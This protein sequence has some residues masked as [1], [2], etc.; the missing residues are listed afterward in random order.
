MK[1]ET[2]MEKCTTY[3][4]RMMSEA[5]NETSEL[6]ALLSTAP[7]DNGIPALDELCEQYNDGEI[8][9]T[10]LVCNTWNRAY[11]AG[12]KRSEARRRKRAEAPKGPSASKAMLGCPFCGSQPEIE[13]WH[14]GGPMKRMVSC[15]NEDCKVSPQ[16]TGSTPATAIERWN[17]RA[18]CGSCC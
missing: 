6:N 11:Y 1:D 9:I 15:Q 10:E 14:G 13:P 7:T 18:A 12:T 16:V 5:K 17:T 3:R 2:E 8:G 4:R